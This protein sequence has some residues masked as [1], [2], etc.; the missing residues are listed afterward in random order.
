MYGIDVK[1]GV[2]RV[3]G[4]G[5]AAV[6]T[7]DVVKTDGFST[8]AEVTAEHSSTT[9]STVL[10][11]ISS[12]KETAKKIETTPPNQDVTVKTVTVASAE[13]GDSLNDEQ[14]AV[15]AKVDGLERKTGRPREKELCSMMLTQHGR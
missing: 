11:K 7:T 2:E 1:N 10:T 9:A 4:S 3:V 5:R 14:L 13:S 12:S 15:L 6:P 8:L